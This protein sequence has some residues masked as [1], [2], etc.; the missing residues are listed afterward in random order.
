MRGPQQG[1]TKIFAKNE[2]DNST[3]KAGL[4]QSET[5]S[6]SQWFFLS[7]NAIEY[8]TIGSFD[9]GFFKQLKRRCQFRK[10]CLQI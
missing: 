8:D 9:V 4:G 1:D 5:Q 2:R 7:K 6:D 3:T 10:E